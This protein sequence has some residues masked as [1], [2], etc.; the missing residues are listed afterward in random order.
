MQKTGAIWRN[1]PWYLMVHTIHH[2]A[3]HYVSGVAA[4]PNL[5]LKDW[6][7]KPKQDLKQ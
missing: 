1:T 2:A 3:F 6:E 7:I 4:A 5:N